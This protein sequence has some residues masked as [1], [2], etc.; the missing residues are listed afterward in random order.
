MNCTYSPHLA[1]IF[2]HSFYS[3]HPLYFTAVCQS[4]KSKDKETQ[5][6]AQESVS[7]A[8]VED[9]GRKWVV[10]EIKISTAELKD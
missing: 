4:L 6:R 5:A 10:K 8:S 9:G 2:V 1:G 3:V 7:V